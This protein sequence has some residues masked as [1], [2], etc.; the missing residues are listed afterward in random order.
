MLK[1]FIVS[2]ALALALLAVD[3][4]SAHALDAC[5]LYVS[6]F[7]LAALGGVA[8]LVAMVKRS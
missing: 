8:G 6:V 3:G 5:A 1:S 7:T 4:L 2:D